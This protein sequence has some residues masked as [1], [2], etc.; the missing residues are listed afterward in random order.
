MK[1]GFDSI[2]TVTPVEIVSIKFPEESLVE[3][4]KEVVVAVVGGFFNPLQ[5]IVK[6]V[7]VLEYAVEKPL[8]N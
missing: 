7:P 1:V 4:V 3:I 2:V 8:V 5:A 6:A